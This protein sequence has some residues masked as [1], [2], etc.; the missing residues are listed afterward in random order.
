MDFE[1]VTEGLTLELGYHDRENDG[2][3]GDDVD[4]TFWEVGGVWKLSPAAKK[5]KERGIV[6]E[7]AAWV[8]S[9]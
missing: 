6:I 8:C 2:C 7:R 3:R 4:G 9:G 5:L 1:R